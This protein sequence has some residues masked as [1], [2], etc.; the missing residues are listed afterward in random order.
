MS[1]SGSPRP[2]TQESS[3]LPVLYSFC[4]SCYAVSPIPPHPTLMV[5]ATLMHVTLCHFP[6]CRWLYNQA[7]N[8]SQECTSLSFAARGQLR[9]PPGSPSPAPHCWVRSP[10]PNLQKSRARSPLHSLKQYT[11]PPSHSHT[12]TEHTPGP[13]PPHSLDHLL[14]TIILTCKSSHN[15]L[16]AFQELSIW[17]LEEL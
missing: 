6:N 13:Y 17:R 12:R 5:P 1:S 7:C 16:W 9:H 4:P 3:S 2:D 14:Q 11:G 15:F 8:F 10:R